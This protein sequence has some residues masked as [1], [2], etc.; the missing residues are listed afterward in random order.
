MV[1]LP[2]VNHHVDAVEHSIIII[3]VEWDVSENIQEI[4]FHFTSA[5]LSRHNHQH[6]HHQH[7]R[8]FTIHIDPNGA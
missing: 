6:H 8:F 2:L 7:Q 4:F 3:R 1:K 5:F